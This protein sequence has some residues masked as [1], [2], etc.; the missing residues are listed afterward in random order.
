MCKNMSTK[1]K[2]VE[3]T[4]AVAVQQEGKKK[5][6]K[7]AAEG[8]RIAASG[9]E[10]IWRS[11]ARSNEINLFGKQSKIYFETIHCDPLFAQILEARRTQTEN[12][13][14]FFFDKT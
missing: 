1:E 14:M 11:N 3:D 10:A 2:Y 7:G 5:H 6:V 12:E 9:W 8:K 13:V 4:R